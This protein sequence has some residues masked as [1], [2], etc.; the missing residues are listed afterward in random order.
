MKRR[1][2]N[3][4]WFES[5]SPAGFSQ[6]MA[7]RKLTIPIFMQDLD[8]FFQCIL[9]ASKCLN[10][11]QLGLLKGNFKLSRAKQQ[12]RLASRMCWWWTAIAQ[13][14]VA[15]TRMGQETLF[16][17]GPQRKWLHRD[18]TGDVPLL[19]EPQENFGS[20]QLKLEIYV[21]ISNSMACHF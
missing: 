8:L 9:S 6:Y 19:Q 18:S 3:K 1:F 4:V 20:C 16:L 10:T 12:Y 7:T 2:Q 11:K 21:S 17:K 13:A 5:I 14:G 15:N